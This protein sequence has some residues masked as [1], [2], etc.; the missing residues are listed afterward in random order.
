MFHVASLA[1][2]PSAFNTT[3][4]QKIFQNS[5]Y[6]LETQHVEPKAI[7]VWW[8][9]NYGRLI[10]G[11]LLRN[12]C[13][14]RS[15]QEKTLL[16]GRRKHGTHLSRDV[17]KKSSAQKVPAEKAYLLVPRKVVS[18]EII[19]TKKPMVELTC[20]KSSKKIA[21]EFDT[22]GFGED[23]RSHSSQKH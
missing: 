15:E 11:S 16:S 18:V 10:K 23:F 21:S 9:T 4:H 12:A 7:K 20:L 3:K 1:H 13:L 2:L 6:T 8:S 22:L 14:G 19:R 5:Y 17:R